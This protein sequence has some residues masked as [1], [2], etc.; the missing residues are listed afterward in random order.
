MNR[1]PDN[2]EA[3]IR[4]VTIVKFSWLRLLTS[5]ATPGAIVGSARSG[6]GVGV[7]GQSIGIGV[8]LLVGRTICTF[9]KRAYFA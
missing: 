9:S 5:G 1:A 3:N 8:G 7:V 2:A 6:P 4:K